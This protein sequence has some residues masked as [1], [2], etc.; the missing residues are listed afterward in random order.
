MRLLLV[1]DNLDLTETLSQILQ[2]ETHSEIDTASNGADA[3]RVLHEAS[4][5]SSSRLT[6]LRPPRYSLIWRWAST[7]RSHPSSEP[8]P[9]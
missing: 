7:V 2:Q 6:V 3:L 4:S 8:R 9:L 5:L 1:D